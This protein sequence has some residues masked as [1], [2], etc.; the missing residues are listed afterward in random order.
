MEP[1]FKSK[2][3]VSKP[4]Q[5]E[6]IVWDFNCTILYTNIKL[7]AQSVELVLYFSN[8]GDGFV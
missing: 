7:G 6:W 5:S 2:K 8:G 1:G 4:S 3:S